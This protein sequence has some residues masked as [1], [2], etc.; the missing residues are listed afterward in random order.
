MLSNEGIRVEMRDCT[1]EN[2][3]PFGY[4]S[5]SI[6]TELKT[7]VFWTI[8]RNV[9]VKTNLKSEEKITKINKIDDKDKIKDDL[10]LEISDDGSRYVT[11]YDIKIKSPSLLLYSSIFTGF[12]T[13]FKLYDHSKISIEGCFIE[14]FKDNAIELYNPKFAKLENWQIKDNERSGVTIEWDDHLEETHKWKVVE[15]DNWEINNNGMNGIEIYWSK[16]A[17]QNL[18]I[19]LNNLKLSNNKEN[20]VLLARM[21]ITHLTINEWKMTNNGA[22]GLIIRS[23]HSRTNKPKF[24]VQK[25]KFNKNRDNGI[26]IEDS[27]VQ[28][29]E[30]EWTNN[31]RSGISIFGTEKPS[32]L[33]SNAIDFLINKP[34]NISIH[35]STINENK[36]CGI[37]ATNHWKGRISISKSNMSMNSLDGVQL[38]NT[39]T[40]M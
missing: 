5:S 35:N 36:Y 1:V 34:M 23:V 27:G 33:P 12:N 22:K 39:F 3:L 25:S 37:T 4:T 19:Q 14:N 26:I 30:V 32:K 7:C 13:M 15:I 21:A 40:E 16:F 28:L 20:G 8:Q 24:I 9:E 38:L 6:L 2:T 29:N 11:K 18:F 10:S 31:F 17:A